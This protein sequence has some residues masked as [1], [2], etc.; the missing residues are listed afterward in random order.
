MFLLI[1][2]DDIFWY[3]K[4]EMM[5]YEI[6]A[7][8]TITCVENLAKAK[9]YLEDTIPDIIIADILLGNQT[10]FS[11]FE[12]EDYR[13]IP[14]IF[15]TAS[16]DELFY[17]H[18]KDILDSFYLI[19]PFHKLSLKS[20]ID[21]T[22]A[23]SKRRLSRNAKGLSVRGARNEK[24]DLKVQDIVSIESEKN[25]CIIKTVKNQYA[26]RASLTQ[27]LQ[28]L[29]P[30]LLQIHKTYLVNKKHITKVSITKSEVWTEIGSLPIGRKYKSNVMEY[31]TENKL[32]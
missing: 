5:L 27:L 15:M 20:A 4:L 11:L 6:D 12:N 1:I 16:D 31:L 8:W 2:E 30:E 19:K 14:V 29:E 13:Q 7:S 21:K 3:T 9:L 32:N 25:Y 26:M 22:I 24:I 23:Q 18:S 10:V 28:E 17:N